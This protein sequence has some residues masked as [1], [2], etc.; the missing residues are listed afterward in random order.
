MNFI[1]RTL[2]SY[3]LILVLAVVSSCSSGSGGGGSSSN[4]ATYIAFHCPGQ[5]EVSPPGI[6]GIDS[7]ETFGSI[8][9]ITGVY[10]STSGESQAFVYNGDLSGNGTCESF[11]YKQPGITVTNTYLY[12]PNHYG[13]FESGLNLVGSYTTSGAG[14]TQFGFLYNG[15]ESGSGTYLT[16]T[17]SESLAATTSTKTIATDTAS[18]QIVIGYYQ[19]PSG[20]NQSFIYDISNEKYFAFESNMDTQA[21]GVIDD[22]GEVTYTIIGNYYNNGVSSGFIADWESSTQTVTNFAIFKYNNLPTTFNGVTSYDRATDYEI[23][24]N[25]IPS[26][27]TT[28]SPVYFHIKRKADGTFRQTEAVSL[29]GYPG[30]SATIANA[31]IG[32]LVGGTHILGY[33]QQG[34]PLSDYGYIATLSGI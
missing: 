27:S 4:N 26:G 2:K 10:I 32:V 3:L 6:S 11:N 8:Y 5:T 1:L 9:H 17:P 12:H 15:R 33:Y 14:D 16:L 29:N 7:V 18:N 34:N 25:Y 20:S 28:S 30:A 31:I 22:L 19:T 13:L 24:A 21:N 23:A